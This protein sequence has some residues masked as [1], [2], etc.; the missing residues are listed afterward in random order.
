MMKKYHV[1]IARVLVVLGFA[2]L[3][4]CGQKDDLYL[5]DSQAQ[6]STQATL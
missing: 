1:Y 3:C 2:L 5:P 4:A 6:I